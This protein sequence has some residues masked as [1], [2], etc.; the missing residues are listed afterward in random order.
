MIKIFF[1]VFVDIDWFREN[2]GGPGRIRED[3]GG[4]EGF[5]KDQR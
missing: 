4:S 1:I 2:Q 3:Q 5:R